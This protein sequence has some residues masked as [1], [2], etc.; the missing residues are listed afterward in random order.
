MKRYLAIILLPVILCSAARPG[1]GEVIPP[2]VWRKTIPELESIREL[3]QRQ[4]NAP[5]RAL[6]RETQGEIQDKIDELLD[7]TVDILSVAD[8]SALRGRIEALRQKNFEDRWTILELR[9]SRVG[10][11]EESVLGDSIEK[12]DRKIETLEA[13]IKE[14][15]TRIAQVRDQFAEELKGMNIPLNT[16]QVDFLLATV[17]GDTVLDISVVFFH[18]RLMTD[19]LEVLTAESLES[20]DV[21]QR[22]YG[23]YTVLLKT[24]LFMYDEAITE[25]DESYLPEIKDIQVRS[26]DL[27]GKTK[28]LMSGSPEA[29]RTVLKNNIQA[30]A[31][32]VEAA[33]LYESYLD[34]QRAEL[35][36][37]R[38][39]LAQDLAVAENTRDTVDMSGDLLAVMQ[40]GE[41][42]FDLLFDLQVPELKPFEN[43]EL[44]REFE[45]I[46]SRIRK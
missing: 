38:K 33:K 36:T 29:H 1:L 31:Y 42:L 5:K 24:V 19:Q 45:K 44:Q 17:V 16:D 2:L 26:K 14:R 25:I 13:G 27:T 11:P 23:M 35:W 41:E 21:A 40:A 7:E 20:L 39:R 3:E 9:E 43:L 22:Y 28:K 46:T 34:A 37:A 10:A 18:V 30:Q 12:I 15:D 32:T 4:K 6:F 8:S